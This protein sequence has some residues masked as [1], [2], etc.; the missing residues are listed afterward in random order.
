MSTKI[1][2]YTKNT[3]PCHIKQEKTSKE[4]RQKILQRAVIK[5]MFGDVT[6]LSRCVA[7]S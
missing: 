3:E 4:K 7:Q 1:E 5:S 6:G 2:E